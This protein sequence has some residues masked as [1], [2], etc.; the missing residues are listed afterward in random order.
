[1]SVA[2]SVVVLTGCLLF[3]PAFIF[4]RLK[5]YCLLALFSFTSNVYA[6]CD[7]FC[8]GSTDTPWEA[9]QFSGFSILV[10]FLTPFSATNNTTENFKRVYSAEE[11]EDARYYLASDGMLQAAYFTSAL[12]RFRRE[13]PDSELN[14][15]AVAALISSQ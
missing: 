7:G 1:M 14:D 15:L 11:Q 10:L 9:T 4:S 5:R 12:Q 13:S 6:H 8:M 2:R 3:M